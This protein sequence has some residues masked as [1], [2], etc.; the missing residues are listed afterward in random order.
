MQFMV[1][2]KCIVYN[3]SCVCEVDIKSNY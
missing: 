3:Q 1:L 2:H